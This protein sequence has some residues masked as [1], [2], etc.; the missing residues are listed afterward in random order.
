MKVIVAGISRTGTMSTQIALEKLGYRTYHMFEAI[1]NQDRGQLDMWNA[2]MEGKSSMDWVKLF[3]GYDA[4]TDLPACIY[5]REMMVAFP[6][7]KI[8]LT[9]RDAESWWKSYQSLVG[10]QQGP[11]DRLLFL[12]RFKKLNRLVEN[13][14][15]VFFKIEPDQYVAEEAIKVFNEHNEAVKATVP[16]DRLFVF[17]VKDGWEPLCKF[18]GVPVPDEPFP[19]ENVGTKQVEKIM[20]QIVIKD[21]LK[22]GLPYLAGIIV[23]VLIIIYLLSI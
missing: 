8:I 16:A 12:P 18:L 17:D 11:V 7:A 19:H 5:W 20:G 22:F 10:S 2:L 21:L 9:I 3:D 14:E 6:D 15:R 1:K 13:I 4:S 23:V